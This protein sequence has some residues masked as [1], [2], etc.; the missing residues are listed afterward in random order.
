MKQ[1]KKSEQINYIT[2]VFNHEPINIYVL[3]IDKK[4]NLIDVLII[5]YDRLPC[6]RFNIENGTDD[7]IVARV[8]DKLSEMF[9]ILVW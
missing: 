9:D 3:G 5:D 1:Y 7:M 4:R 6:I 2:T 8:L